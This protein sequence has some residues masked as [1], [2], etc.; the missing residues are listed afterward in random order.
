MCV[1][2]LF[3][4][5]YLRFISKV[6][7]NML[8]I[9]GGVVVC[10]STNTSKSSN[11]LALEETRPPSASRANDFAVV[12]FLQSSRDLSGVKSRPSRRSTQKSP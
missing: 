7:L 10:V 2:R 11:P 9:A 8:C 3:I 1:K 6:K 5:F 4:H 12:F